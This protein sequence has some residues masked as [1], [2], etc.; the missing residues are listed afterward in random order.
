MVFLPSC[1]K[2]I[3][4]PYFENSTYKNLSSFDIKISVFRDIFKTE[5]IIS[6]NDSL[7]QQIDLDL[8]S[9]LSDGTIM[10]AD[11]ITILFDEVRTSRFS[12]IDTSKFNIID[13]DNFELVRKEKN[14][15]FYRYTFT[16]DDYNYA[17]AK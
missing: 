7:V 2:K 1:E 4:K 15:S 14:A 10:E 17:G 12:R 3:D 13:L 16:I 6:D 9:L 8:G 11:S 5:Y